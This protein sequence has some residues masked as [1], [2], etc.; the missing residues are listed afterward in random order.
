MKSDTKDPM[1]KIMDAQ[2][3]GDE[4]GEG[5]VSNLAIQIPVFLILVI[6]FLIVRRR[7]PWIYYPNV[8]N[9]RQHPVYSDAE[10]K[11]RWIKTLFRVKDTQL[12]GLIG[13]DSFMFLQTLK[14]FLNI[15]IV[16]CV[17]ICPVLC[18]YFYWK[19]SGEESFFLKLSNKGRDG[20]CGLLMMVAMCYFVSLLVFYLVF[21]YYKRYIVLRQIYLT[22]P[23]TMTSIARLK[24]ISY[25]L[26]DD[27]TVVD[28]IDVR[29]RTVLIDKLPT[30]IVTDSQC[31]Q[32]MRNLDIGEVEN[33]VLVKDTCYLQRLVEMKECLLQDIEK[34]IDRI[35]TEMQ[36][37]FVENEVLVRLSFRNS[38]SS[39][40]D[41]ARGISDDNKEKNVS[42]NEFNYSMEEKVELSNWF[43]ANAERFCHA[44]GIKCVLRLH[45]LKLKNL[46][47]KIAYE[48]QKIIFENKPVG[49]STPSSIQSLSTDMIEESNRSLN[50]VNINVNNNLFI[51]PQNLD[52]QSFFSWNQIR[53]FRRNRVLFTLDIPRGRRKAFVTF[54]DRKTTSIVMQSSI[55]SKVFSCNASQAPAPYDILWKNLPVDDTTQYFAST[56][57]YFIFF[58]II[59]S[60]S[61]AAIYLLGSLSIEQNSQNIFF[62]FIARYKILSSIYSGFIGP[63]VYNL[64]QYLITFIFNTLL[65]LQGITSYSVFQAKLMH[66]F[67]LFSFFNSFLFICVGSI[68]YD[69]ITATDTSNFTFDGIITATEKSIF[70]SSVFFVNTII[71]RALI[72]TAIV[73][74]KPAPFL[75]NFVVAPLIIRTRRQRRELSYVPPINFGIVIPDSLVVF[76]IVMGYAFIS[77]IIVFVGLIFYLFTFIVYKNDLLY[78]TKNEYESGGIYWIFTVKIIVYS[79]LIFQA[80]LFIKA[81]TSEYAFVTLLLLPLLLFDY[82]YVTGLKDM[83]ERN[84][85]YYPLNSREESY[86]DAFTSET[87]R[88][89][90]DMLTAWECDEDDSG[91]TDTLLIAEPSPV[92]PFTQNPSN[93]AKA[94]NAPPLTNF[95]QDPSLV[96]EKSR[97]IL[98]SYFYIVIK[99]IR[100]NDS[101]NI[102]Q[103]NK[104]TK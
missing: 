16:I 90:L 36:R 75:F 42:G 22:S 7:K 91:D 71:Q 94:E 85:K 57:S 93:V 76:S 74:I 58:L 34:E 15:M 65:N 1:K 37:H 84:S 49:V 99:Y 80:V 25:K 83:F 28:A 12:L 38:N 72:G 51:E 41:S 48:R 73:L 21:I 18:G 43:L 70:K 77:P 3:S 97:L 103:M 9:L 98:P 69:I 100:E 87:L 27:L 13:L 17:S 102:F 23:S 66:A 81:Y 88:Q 24:G 11:Y 5:I 89:R 64:L 4:S 35:F 47:D 104:N 60:Y 2:V 101:D 55:G 40:I 44:R 53:N 59:V 31:I 8:K 79:V 45:L 29:S 67:S 86:L 78:A 62:R 6:V 56:I 95:Y 61:Y 33:A 19:N 68:I 30:E 63:C 20:R 32:Y 96:P 14:L 50:T 10:S 39:L 54:C 46:K 26:P 82:M 92:S 52:D